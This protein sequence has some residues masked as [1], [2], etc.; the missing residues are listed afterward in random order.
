MR[1]EQLDVGELTVDKIIGG[2][3][4]DLLAKGMGDEFFINAAL[5]S[6]GNTGKTKDKPI[7]SLT[8]AYGMARSG[9]NDVIHLQQSTSSVSLASNL[10]WA[11]NM[12]HLIGVWP[13]SCEHA[14][15]RIGM[16]TAF[17][18]FITV[19]GYGNLFANLY[20][21]HGTAEADYVGWSISGARNRFRNVHF[22]GPFNE[23]QADHT[24]YVGVDLTGT[25]NVFDGCIFGDSSIARNAANYNVQLAAGVTAHF[26]NCLFRMF[27]DGA[28][29]MFVNFK[30]SSG[31]T[32]AYFHN[33]T[34]LALS[35][36]LATSIDEAFNFT[37]GNTALA[38]LDPMC[39]FVKVT[40]IAAAAKDQY[41]YMPRMHVTTTIDEGNIA[42]VLVS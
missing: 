36:N 39:N 26:H 5:G 3:V 42:E 8:G 41:V 19:S 17:S 7:T 2:G 31:V 25:E 38:L 35:S 16:S 13:G 15:S 10:A 32:L 14:R 27:V 40:R 24:S 37:G 4:G 29:S 22:G 9:Y 12:A 34:F 33:C 30:N 23:D 28:D 1:Y 11:K 6:T 18:P 21:M 20:T